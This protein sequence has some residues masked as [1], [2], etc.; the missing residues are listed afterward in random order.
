MKENSA[1]TKY[2]EGQKRDEVFNFAEGYRKFIS[3][4]K[5]ERECT[6]FIYAD[7]KANGFLD[8]DELIASNKSLK[9]GD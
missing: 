7:A 4:C 6:S 2:P 9:A 3:D 8:M 5:T 1:W